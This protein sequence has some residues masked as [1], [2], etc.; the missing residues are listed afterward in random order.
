MEEK[1]AKGTLK[2]IS[3]KEP[4]NAISKKEGN[5]N[6]QATVHDTQHRKLRNKHHNPIKTIGYFQ[7]LRKSKI[8]M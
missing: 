8:G 4:D 7:V 3:R 2:L 5:I 6:R 1:D